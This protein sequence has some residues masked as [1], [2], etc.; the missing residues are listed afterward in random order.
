MHLRALDACVI[1]MKKISLFIL[2]IFS[3]LLIISCGESEK[4]IQARVKKEL[5]DSIQ[6]QR[7]KEEE[8]LRQKEA[9]EEA[10]RQKKIEAEQKK[11]REFDESQIGK[12]WNYL[13]NYLKNPY[14]AQL[15]SY[16]DPKEPACKSLANDIHIDGL[17]IACY[18][19]LA[20]NGFGAMGEENYFVFFKNG[21]PK[22]FDTA[23]SIANSS[24]TAIEACLEL[25]GF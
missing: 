10:E 20:E 17:S 23:E 2:C 25:H 9:A 22:Y 4:E 19:V 3:A 21:K 12:G 7:E 15:I 14:S 18:K 16:A 8:A 13:R 6:K 11:Q 24:S 1:F 5:Q